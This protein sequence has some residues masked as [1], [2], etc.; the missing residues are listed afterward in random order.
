M[1]RPLS[2][3][4]R[5]ALFAEATDEDGVAL[6][7][8]RDPE[9]AETIR[10]SS[11]ALECV[12]LDPYLLGVVS[13]GETY[14]YVEFALT[15]PEDSDRTP[16]SIEIQLGHITEETV[17]L[18]RSSIVPAQVTIELVSTERPD[19]VEAVFP[20]FDLVA[21]DYDYGERSASLSLGIDDMA[22]EPYPADSYTPSTAPGLF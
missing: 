4:F 1:S 6:V 18:L 7:T 20:D 3:A 16:P 15:L 12:S 8:I 2:N 13:R 11:H 22:S 9:L 19:L 10:A 5:A 17:A 14:L 21:A